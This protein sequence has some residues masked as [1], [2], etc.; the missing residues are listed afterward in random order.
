MDAFVIRGGRPLNGEIEVS[1][2]KNA[3]LPIMAAALLTRERCVI[4]RVPDLSDVRFMGQILQSMGAKV[5][6]DGSTVTIEAAQVR[7]FGD[8]ELIRK[9]R[10]SICILGP[11]MG[12]LGR[13]R[14]ALPGGCVIGARPIDLHLK[15]LRALGASGPI[16]CI[17]GLRVRLELPGVG[18]A[19]ANM[20]SLWD[21]QSATLLVNRAVLTGLP[22][23]GA[24]LAEGLL[25]CVY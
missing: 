22:E 5:E 25:P 2:S 16:R 13:A 21:P 11:L 6:F 20:D 24:L 4:R 15:G 9:M 12:R 14:V 10:G 19:S 1:G 3:T 17:Q 7:E 23:Q 18:V 8:Y